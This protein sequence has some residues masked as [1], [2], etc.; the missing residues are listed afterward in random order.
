MEKHKVD[1]GE[2]NLPAHFIVAL[3]E[4]PLPLSC[5]DFAKYYMMM[6]YPFHLH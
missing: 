5:I 1:V 6:Y 2:Y 4:I 3:K